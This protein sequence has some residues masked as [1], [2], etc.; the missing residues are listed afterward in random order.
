MTHK[1]NNKHKLKNKDPGQRF[2][3]NAR[4]GRPNTK[5][6]YPC[7]ILIQTNNENPQV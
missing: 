4:L 1:F 7:G 6:N 2:T 5:Q 3:I